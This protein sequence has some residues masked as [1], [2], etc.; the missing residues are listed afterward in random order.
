MVRQNDTT[1]ITT[2]KEVI[3]DDKVYE[4]PG[5]GDRISIRNGKVY[6]NGYELVNGKWQK[7]PELIKLILRKLLRRE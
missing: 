7:K 6:I 4:K 3:I 2:Y 1:I 5:I